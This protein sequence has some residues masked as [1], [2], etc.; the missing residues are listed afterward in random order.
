VSAE[1]RKWRA[2]VITNYSFGSDSILG[3]KA[4]GFGVG[5]GV[6]WQDKVGIGYPT[7]RNADGSVKIDVAHPYYGPADTSIDAWI[8][9]ERPIWQKRIKW[10]VQLNG[11]NLFADRDLIPITVQPWGE[12]ATARIPPER[13]W[14]L[15]NTFSF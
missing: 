9:Y 13:R 12:V 5:G 10:R 11:R 14:Y 1:Q 4:K 8:S 7:T 15:T 2:N 6:R 3:P